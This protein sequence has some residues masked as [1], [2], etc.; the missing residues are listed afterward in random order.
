[1]ATSLPRPR[2]PGPRGL[3]Q[4]LLSPPPPTP[5]AN[6]T[7]PDQ[8]QTPRLSL[9]PAPPPRTHPVSLPRTS[10][11]ATPLPGE[12]HGAPSG[13]RTRTAGHAGLRALPLLPPPSR[14]GNRPAPAAAAAAAAAAA[15]RARRPPRESEAGNPPQGLA[16]RR[17]VSACSPRLRLLRPVF[18]AR[19]SFCI[20]WEEP[21]RKTYLK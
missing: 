6:T 17:R 7:D 4:R 13:L 8:E 3:S 11:K 18:T 14:D 1:M 5:P 21:I 9:S 10:P 16:L 15:T 2:E 19:G 12:L 20:P